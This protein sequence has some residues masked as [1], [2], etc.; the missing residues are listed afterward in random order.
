M[1]SGIYSATFW[2]HPSTSAEYRSMSADVL[3]YVCGA[4]QYQL[5]VHECLRSIPEYVQ[6][7]A[8]YGG[9]VLRYICGHTAVP[10]RTY[11]SVSWR[12]S[13]TSGTY[14]T[15]FWRYWSIPRTYSGMFADLLLYG[16]E[17]HDDIVDIQQYISDV[18]NS[19]AEA[20]VFRRKALRLGYLE[21]ECRG[22]AAGLGLGVAAGEAVRF[23]DSEA[24]RF[25]VF[26][27]ERNEYAC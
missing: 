8:V 6:D 25:H 1:M 24:A 3:L 14:S 7:I 27:T 21:Q 20:L 19:R 16:R 13:T 2:R 15:T 10:P 18:I 17:V 11:L 23:G 9:E 4:Q 22:E 12:S 26:G 5:E